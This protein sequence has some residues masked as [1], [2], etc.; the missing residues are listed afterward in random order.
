ML[1]FANVFS[2]GRVSGKSVVY[3]LV[4]NGNVCRKSGKIGGMRGKMHEMDVGTTSL[5]YL[6]IVQTGGRL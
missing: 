3:L 6:K 2:A 1:F 5:F 4:T